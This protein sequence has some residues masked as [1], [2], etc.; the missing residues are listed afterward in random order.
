MLKRSLRAPFFLSKI[1]V[2][3]IKVALMN[4]EEL[5]IQ[6]LNALL[7]KNPTD[8][9][10]LISLAEILIKGRDYNRSR[11]LVHRSLRGQFSTP[12]LMLRA[13]KLLSYFGD[14]AII[15]SIIAQV[16]PAMWDSAK[17]L[18]EVSHILSIINANEDSK[19]F[20]LE[21]VKR[22]AGHPPSLHMLATTEL[23]FGN[24]ERVNE[25]AEK[26]LTFIPDD[27]GAHWLLARVNKG[28]GEARIERIN[29]SLE[30]TDNPEYRSRMFYALH[31]EHHNL[32]QYDKAWR[33]LEQGH[34]ERSKVFPYD[35]SFYEALFSKLKNIS[36]DAHRPGLDLSAAPFKS[37]FILGLHRSG[38]TLT[39]RIISG[40]SKVSAG[41]ES[42]DFTIQLRR[43]MNNPFKAENDPSVIDAIDKLDFAE[44]AQGYIEAMLW[45]AK[46]KPLLT[47]KLPSNYLNIPLI[48]RALPNAKFIMLFRDPIDVAFSNMR[49]LFSTAATYSYS[50]ET[51]AHFF[52]LFDDYRKDLL[53]KYPDRIYPLHYENLVADPQL[54]T[55]KM[56]EFLGL[57]FE[58]DM[59]DIKSRKESVATASSI[60][61][62]DGIRKDR[63]KVWTTYGEYL[64]PL[65][66]MLER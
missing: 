7:E 56:C 23:F 22:D 34:K 57:D 8:S 31:Y 53:E 37:I 10:S 17:S 11:F 32:Q 14:A 30:T 4:T 63:S 24:M 15:K 66:D 58:P 13:L 29:K 20:A 25:L 5:D 35:P 1:K 55:E 62:R 47:D 19:E 39:E 9:E 64:S 38:T 3:H 44:I 6:R 48:I 65:I 59:V 54:E 2:A 45:R 28:D 12:K 36:A 61:M 52:K 41:E 60:M 43:Q 21:A 27:P 50:L 46:D 51:T 49:T 16:R 26:C 18:S 40:H 33:A 42:Y